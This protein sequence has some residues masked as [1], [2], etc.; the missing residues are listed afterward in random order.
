ML[1]AQATSEGTLEM[2][3][4]EVELLAAT[5]HPNVVQIFA[6]CRAE[7]ALVME[8]MHGGSLSKHLK[9]D[10]MAWQDR[11]RVLH[12]V[13]L[14]VL[15]LHSQ[16]SPI[17]HRDIKPSNVLMTKDMHAKVADMGLSKRI[18]SGKSKLSTN[19]GVPGTLAY[20]DP[21]YEE[22]GKFGPASDVYS[23]G[24]TIAV[25]VTNR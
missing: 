8:M 12:E 14:A 19:L 9:A 16:A 20:V 3:D 23:L 6:T 15:Y 2:Y 21:D 1:N 5:R 22:N 25:T 24:M 17:M 13:A 10:T 18:S 7:R 4:A 11:V